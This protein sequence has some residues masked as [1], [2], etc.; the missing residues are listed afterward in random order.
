VNVIRPVCVVANI[1]TQ[2]PNQVPHAVS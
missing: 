1:L 2:T